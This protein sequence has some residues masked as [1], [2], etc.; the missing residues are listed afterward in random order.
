MNLIILILLKIYKTEVEQDSHFQ[1]NGELLS[2]EPTP[3]TPIEEN[4]NN[5]LIIFINGIIQKPVTN[6]YLKVELHFVFTKAP[7][8]EDEVEIYYYKGV[9]GVDL[10]QR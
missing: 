8:P 3:G 6:L 9:D 2:F 1:Y 7:L 5:I 10:V 4:I